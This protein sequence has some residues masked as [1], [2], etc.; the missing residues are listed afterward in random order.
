MSRD[1]WNYKNAMPFLT[2]AE[3]VELVVKRY[4][5]ERRKPVDPAT[6]PDLFAG[7]A[8]D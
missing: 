5:R 7:V 1:A 6:T 3:C 8:G 2:P 4:Q